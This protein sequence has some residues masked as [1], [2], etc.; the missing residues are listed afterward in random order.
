MAMDH[1]SK[2]NSGLQ[3]LI[4]RYRKKFQIPENLNYYSSEHYKLAERKYLKH[5]LKNG[6]RKPD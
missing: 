3:L 6:V 1:K 4:D 5:V 2:Q